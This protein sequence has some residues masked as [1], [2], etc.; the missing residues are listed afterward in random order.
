MKR[1]LG[2]VALLVSICLPTSANAGLQQ[3]TDLFVFGDSLS[4]GGNSGLL[5][6]AALAG[7]YPPAPYYNG[8]YSNGLVAVEYL[9][10]AYNPGSTNFKPS[11]AGG[12]N[13]AVGGATTGITSFNTVTPTVPAALQPVYAGTSNT[14]QLFGSPQLTGFFSS[15]SPDFDPATSLF[16]VWFFPN[17]VFNWLATDMLPGTVQGGPP[18]HG[19]ASDLISNGISNIVETISVLAAAG[20]QHFLVPNLPNIGAIP[21]AG[22]GGSK[23]LLDLTVAFNVAIASTLSYLD[24]NVLLSGEIVQFDTYSLVNKV[25]AQPDAYGFDNAKDPCFV[26]S[27]GSMCADPDKYVFWD[28]V[29][30]TTAAHEILGAGLYAAVVPEPS[31]IA[32]FALGLFGIVA[33]RRRKLP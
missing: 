11:L 32:L 5:S 8:Q 9:W 10:R 17:D 3:L 26:A 15:P 18:E 27:S 33:R 16:V 6:Q 19:D 28:E 14:G 20:A 7:T 1:L 31:T 12:T 22:P 24:T 23:D 21:L 13:Y 29:H 4:D 25:L 30:P 2:A